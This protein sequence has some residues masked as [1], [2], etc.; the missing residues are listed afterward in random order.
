MMAA[1]IR[2]SIPGVA[3]PSTAAEEMSPAYAAALAAVRAGSI[4][5]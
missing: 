1:S 5:M 3:S 2:T 4:Q